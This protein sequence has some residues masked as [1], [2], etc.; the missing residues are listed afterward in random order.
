MLVKN[1]ANS[2]PGRKGADVA[3]VELGGDQFLDQTVFQ[4]RSP[5]DPACSGRS[6]RGVDQLAEADVVEQLTLLLAKRR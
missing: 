6:Y 3:V 5:W 4:T 2:R 1:V